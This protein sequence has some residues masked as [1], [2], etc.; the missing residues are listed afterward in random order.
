MKYIINVTFFAILSIIF[1]NSNGQASLAASMDRTYNKIADVNWYQFFRYKNGIK[2]P[3]LILYNKASSNPQVDDL[4][5]IRFGKN[6]VQYQNRESGGSRWFLYDDKTICIIYGL[7]LY[8]ALGNEKDEVYEY[9]H[10]KFN[11]KE[12]GLLEIFWSD[13]IKIEY[14]SR[15]WLTNYSEKLIR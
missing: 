13:D 9:M 10:V 5:S 4:I 7:T 2:E 12:D 15:D 11:F 6:G 8:D 1:H 3:E 14:A